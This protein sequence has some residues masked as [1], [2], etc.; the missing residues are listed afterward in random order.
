MIHK[1]QK[2]AKEILQLREKEYKPGVTLI[3]PTGERKLALSICQRY[4]DRQTYSGLLQWVIADDGTESSQDALHPT[5]GK[6]ELSYLRR[7]SVRDKTKSIT[8]NVSACLFAVN[9]DHVLIIEDDDWYRPTYIEET[10]Q[11]LQNCQLAGEGYSKYYNIPH[12]KFRVNHNL[13]HASLFQTALK[14]TALEYL[15]VSC[16]KRDSAFID[17]RLWNKSGLPKKIFCDKT[18]SIGI[19][20][21]PGRNGIG[22]GHRPSKYS[23]SFQSDREWKVLREWIGKEDA[24]VYI[25]IQ[26]QMAVTEK[27]AI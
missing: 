13:E 12:Q 7:S 2:V 11:R 19:K 14:A 15:W 5:S 18:T 3:T 22:A 6:Y 1:N 21:L 20:G 24:E 26:R 25:E 16:L 9:Y 17:T 4:I 8:G 27:E 10:L 23:R